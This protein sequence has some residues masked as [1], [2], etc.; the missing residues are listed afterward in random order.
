LLG[1]IIGAMT[2]TEAKVSAAYKKASALAFEFDDVKVNQVNQIA[3]NKFLAG[4]K[5]DAAA[6]SGLIKA[7]NE[8]RLYI[9]TSTIKSKKFTTEAVQSSGTAVGVDVPIIKAAVGGSVGIKTGGVNNSKVTYSGETPLV[10]GFQAARME[11]EPGAF[12]GLKQ[13]NPGEGALRKL[14]PGQPAGAAKPAF[15]L[16]ESTGPFV[17]FK[18]DVPATPRPTAK[19]SGI[20]KAATSGAKKGA[21]RKASTSADRKGSKSAPKKVAKKSAKKATKKQLPRR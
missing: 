13:I 3:V 20:K 2:G 16:L 5:V 10:F 19:K 21:L 12:L 6:G 14:R 15:E 9:I 17:N 7:L 1:G 18:E 4:A 8:D 11:V